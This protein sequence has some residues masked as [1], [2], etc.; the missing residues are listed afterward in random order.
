MAVVSRWPEGSRER[1]AWVRMARGMRPL[2]RALDS[3]RVAA[4]AEAIGAE[5]LQMVGLEPE[6]DENEALA[7]AAG[8]RAGAAAAAVEDEEDEEGGAAA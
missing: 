7:A 5:M 4:E 1:A 6:D 2:A 8:A 3:A